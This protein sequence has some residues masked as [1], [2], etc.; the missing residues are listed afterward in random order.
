VRPRERTSQAADQRREVVA[1]G[2]AV[3]Q[4]FQRTLGGHFLEAFVELR[5]IDRALALASKLFI[6]I[7]PLSI[8]ITAVLS[9]DSFGDDLVARFG[10]TGSGAEA[11]RELFAAPTQVQAGIGLLGIVILVSS[12]LSFARALE[13]VYLDCWE[14]PPATTGA[15][16]GRLVWLVGCII[17]VSLTSTANEAVESAGVGALGW[18]LAMVVGGAFFLWTPYVLLGRRIPARRLLP[19]GILSGAALL[20]FAVGSDVI[21]PELVTHNT[22]RYGLIGF[23]FSLVTWLFSGA[24]LVVAAA[25]LG[26]LVDRRIVRSG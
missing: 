2:T 16:G 1:S 12:I 25:I 24:V 20:V 15:A 3:W 14:L 19:T 13:R 18:L 8:L 5:A 21:M 9:G 4:A 7:L 23:T 26:A 11:A 17:M 6:A 10:L 22:I